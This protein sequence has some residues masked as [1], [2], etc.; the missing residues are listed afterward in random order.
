M[1]MASQTLTGSVAVCL[2]AI[3]L[4]AQAETAEYICLGQERGQEITAIA[5]S[6]AQA[7]ALVK[8][9]WRTAGCFKK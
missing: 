9:H 5:G 2:L 3:S 6:E 4:N 7:V 8:T 1:N